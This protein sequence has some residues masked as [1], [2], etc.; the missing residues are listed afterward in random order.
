MIDLIKILELHKLKG[1]K[2]LLAVSGGVDSMVL[3]EL[4][5]V[6]NLNFCVATCDF[7]LRDDSH[8]EVELVS[9]YCI[10]HSIEFYSTKFDTVNFMQKND[11]AVQEAARKLRYQ[12]FFELKTNVGYDTLV[13]A[14]HLD[15]N[16]ETFLINTIRGIWYYWLIINESFWK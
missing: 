14:H 2:F 10:K 6:A 13:T 5:R 9:N 16:I 3:L 4:F 8:N 12:Y 15:D 1:N 11:I 7:N